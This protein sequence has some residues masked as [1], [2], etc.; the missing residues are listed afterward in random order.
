AAK[1]FNFAERWGVKMDADKGI[2]IACG[3]DK[4]SF[5][6]CCV[7]LEVEN[8]ARGTLKIT[9]VCQAFECGAIMNPSDLKSQVQGGIV[10]G[11]GPALREAIAFENG[12]VTN[13]SFHTY[14]VPRFNDLPKL[15]I[16]L[17]NRP[18]LQSVGAGETPIIAIA[19][20]IGNALFHASG[21]RA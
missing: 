2:G 16:V 20:A 15:D 21:C 19:P 14:Q 17:V 5:V 11:L 7:A 3:I 4:G 9:E 13:A 1:K 10:M 8:R 18:D 12:K 6:A